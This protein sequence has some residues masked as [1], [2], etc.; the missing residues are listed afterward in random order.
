MLQENLFQINVVLL[1]FLFIKESVST[2]I[3]VFN[4]DNDQKSVVNQYIRV[5]SED[6]VT[7]DW[8][9]DAE[10]SAVHHRIFK[11]KTVILYYNSSVF[12]VFLIK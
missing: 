2:K 3:S 9:N 4:T 11:E 12:T 10:H 6:H 1:S 7:E 5:I 8:G